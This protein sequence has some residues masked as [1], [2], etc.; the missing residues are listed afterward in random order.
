MSAAD[1]AAAI[2]ACRGPAELER[3]LE[4]KT[5]TWADIRK[6]HE[7]GR[8]EGSETLISIVREYREMGDSW[9]KAIRSTIGFKYQLGCKLLKVAEAITRA[10]YK[11]NGEQAI[12]DAWDKDHQIA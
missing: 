10:G 7:A 9:P 11:L 4:A 1:T 3:L 2:R 6:A 12:Q 8:Q 5:Y